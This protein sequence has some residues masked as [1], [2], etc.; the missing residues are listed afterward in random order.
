MTLDNIQIVLVETSHPGNIGATA[1]AMKTMGLTKLRLVQPKFFPHADAT[2]RASGA[3]DL[4]QSA[5]VYE[6][7]GEA[8]ADCVTVAATSARRRTLHWPSV[9]PR[10]GAV[11]LLADATAGPVAL[12]FGRE[13]TGLSNDELDL[14]Q[15]LVHIPTAESY[16]SLNLAM[17]VQVLAYELRVAAAASDATDEAVRELPAA[18]ELE[19][20]YEHLGEVMEQTGFLDPDNPRYLM[21]RMRLLLNRAQP[22]QNEVNILRGFLAAVQTPRRRR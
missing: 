9:E 6:S 10:S 8:V 2:A 19:R 5:R 21:R 20:L 11:R 1:R 7:L 13:R 16:G 17:A 18:A 14:C 3:D 12:V 4:L 15:W 22:D